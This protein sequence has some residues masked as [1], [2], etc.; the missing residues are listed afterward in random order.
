MELS[1]RR[2]PVVLQFYLLKPYNS[3][4]QAFTFSCLEKGHPVWSCSCWCCGAR[5][6]STDGHMETFVLRGTGAGAAEAP[7][8]IK[9]SHLESC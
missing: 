5:L 3:K 1:L 9:V 2:K 7:P 4:N 6:D 8:D